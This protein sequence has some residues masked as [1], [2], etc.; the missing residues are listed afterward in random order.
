MSK[1]IEKV[2]PNLVYRKNTVEMSTKFRILTKIFLPNSRTCLGAIGGRGAKVLTLEN[3]SFRM[4][5]KQISSSATW[6]SQ[7]FDA[8]LFGSS[9]KEDRTTRTDTPLPRSPK[10]NLS[11]YDASNVFTSDRKRCAS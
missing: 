10:L 7:C 5:S 8:D 4:H 11:K 2:G 3:V 1:K 6:G 9:Q